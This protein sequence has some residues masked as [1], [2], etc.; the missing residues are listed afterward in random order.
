MKQEDSIQ[1]GALVASEDLPSWASWCRCRLFRLAW[2]YPSLEH[3]ASPARVTRTTGSLLNVPNKDENIIFN[4][5]I[6]DLRSYVSC[7]LTVLL[8]TVMVLSN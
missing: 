2:A 7:R 6:Y 3:R 1:I 4:I 5:S 8:S